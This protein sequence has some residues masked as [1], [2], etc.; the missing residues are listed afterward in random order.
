MHFNCNSTIFDLFLNISTIEESCIK[1]LEYSIE[2][3]P[4]RLNNTERDCCQ[5]IM[6]NVVRS[7]KAF[8]NNL[9]VSAFNFAK[10]LCKIPKNIAIASTKEGCASALA[11]VASDTQKSCYKSLGIPFSDKLALI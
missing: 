2:D 1:A 9:A 8:C 5:N 11:E 3:V 10:S 6:T 4:C 7:V